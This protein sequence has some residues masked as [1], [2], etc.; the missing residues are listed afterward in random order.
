MN[1]NYSIEQAESTLNT[2]FIQCIF[3]RGGTVPRKEWTEEQKHEGNKTRENRSLKCILSSHE[4][5]GAPGTLYSF[6]RHY[7]CRK[8]ESFEFEF[9]Y[10]LARICGKK[11]GVFIFVLGA[12]NSVCKRLRKTTERSLPNHTSLS[13]WTDHFHSRPGQDPILRQKRSHGGSVHQCPTGKPPSI[14]AVVSSKVSPLG[15]SN[16]VCKRLRSL[17]REEASGVKHT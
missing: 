14:P 16:F 17:L 15:T 10:F 13:E 5:G 6:D 11:L 9:V 3:H 12:A 7:L 4:R 8:Q 2:N 1:L